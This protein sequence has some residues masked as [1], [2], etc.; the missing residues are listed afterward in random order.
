VAR[1]G[2][3]EVLFFQP[4]SDM[5]VL[6]G[7]GGQLGSFE[8]VFSPAGTHGKPKPL[9]NRQ[10][11]AIDLAVAEAWQAYDIRLKL[12]RNWPALAP[13][14]RG[15]IH[16]YVG[17]E[18]TFYLEGAVKRLQKSQRHLHSDA[19]IEI[20]PGKNHGTLVDHKLRTRI[21]EEMAAQFRRWKET[22][23]TRDPGP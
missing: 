19:V 21:A 16:V 20:F 7:H 12:E 23:R 22:E 2:G 14:L 15:K 3:R 1:R 5:E 13:K 11:G 8:A 18:D 6:I 4:F 17:G 9:W 10:T